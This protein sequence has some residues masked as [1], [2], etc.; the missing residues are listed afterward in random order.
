MASIITAKTVYRL[1]A[2]LLCIAKL[3]TSVFLMS[4]GDSQWAIL[5]NGTLVSRDTW[6]VLEEVNSG[7]IVEVKPSILG[8]VTNI[9]T[10]LMMF[11]GIV[12][13]KP[14]WLYP[15]LMNAMVS[16]LFDCISAFFYSVM[17]DV[18]REN[19]VYPRFI[20]IFSVVIVGQVIL[21]HGTMRF[22][23]AIRT[24]RTQNE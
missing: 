17:D 20:T 24:V 16:L 9:I 21:V 1:M 22:L 10:A 8:A 15:A 7:I 2:I 6:D 12:T 5:S 14:K 11:Y 23:R 19:V 3:V 4:T 13:N 18:V